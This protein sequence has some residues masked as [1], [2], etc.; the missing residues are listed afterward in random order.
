MVNLENSR[1]VQWLGHC[2]FTAKDS[3]SIPGWGTK[4]PQAT[5]FDQEII[6]RVCY[7][8]IGTLPIEY[9]AGTPMRKLE[10]PRLNFSQDDIDAVRNHPKCSGFKT[11]MF[12]VFT[13]LGSEVQLGLTEL[14]IRYG[15]TASP[16][17]I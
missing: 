16:T 17:Q 2:T 1:A 10:K 8:H 15:G 12:I 7:G 6:N 5:Q 9:N 11:D 4:I 14:K 13:G 3:G